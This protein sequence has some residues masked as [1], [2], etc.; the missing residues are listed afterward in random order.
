[1]LLTDQERDN[2][3][4]SPQRLA[5]A[6]DRFHDTGFVVLENAYSRAWVEDARR[7]C[8][9]GLA[10]YLE[11]KGGL[12]GLADR[13]F[14][15][16][17]VAWFPPLRGILAD[18]RLIAHPISRQILEIILGPG[19]R[20]SFHNTNTSFPESGTQPVHR[21]NGFLFGNRTVSGQPCAQVVAN[22]CLCDFTLENGATELWPGTHWIPDP[23]DWQSGDLETRSRGLPS[24]RLVEPAG[25]LVLRDLRLWHRGMPNGTTSER[26]MTATVYQRAWMDDSRTTVPRST[27]EQ[28]PTE[29][30][31]VFRHNPVVD[32]ARHEPR[33][34]YED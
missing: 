17:H 34:W 9:D 16:G 29:V 11:T 13:T 7:A 27:W 3:Q 28:W 22:V 30:R 23:V 10:G 12:A 21:D 6:L 19:Y 5:I 33:R 26:S 25:T 15:P 4:L 8:A 2:G 20:S 31:N 1:M 14:G 24:I 32:D 18:D